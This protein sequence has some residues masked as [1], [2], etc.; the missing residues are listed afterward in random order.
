MAPVRL[1]RKVNTVPQIRKKKEQKK[2]PI[3]F[4]FLFSVLV[5][6]L[7]LAGQTYV[8]PKF[9][10][11]QSVQASY[12]GNVAVTAGFIFIALFIAAIFFSFIGE[13][14]ALPGA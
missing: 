10:Q 3:L 2:M 9:S 4:A 12:A 14:Q 1:L 6:M 11:L 7:L 5:A 8:A 13:K